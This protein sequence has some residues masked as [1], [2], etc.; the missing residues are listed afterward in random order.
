MGAAELASRTAWITALA[1]AAQVSLGLWRV[2]VMPASTASFRSISGALLTGHIVIGVA[3][4]MVTFIH[5]WFAMKS[6]NIRETSVAGLWVA[7]AVLLLLFVQAAVGASLL[8]QSEPQRME[9]RRLHLAVAVIV[10]VLAGAHVL[11]NR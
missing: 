11:L 6:P 7:T 9:F 10:V 1:L 2:R 3:L 4:P 8:W 5:A